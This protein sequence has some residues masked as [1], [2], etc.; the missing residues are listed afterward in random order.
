MS[1]T[2]A[3]IRIKYG[4]Q[5]ICD[6][7]HYVPNQFSPIFGK[8]YQINGTVPKDTILKIAIFDHDTLSKDDLIG[9]TKIDVEDRLRSKYGAACGLQKEYE[10]KGYN[11]WRHPLQP[12]EIL[13]NLCH[14]NDLVPPEYH[15]DHVKV[16]GIE[17][18]DNSLVT[19]DSNV[20]E[21]LA[22]SALNKFKLIPCIGHPLVPEHVETRSLYRKDRPGIE[23]GK[24]QMWIEIFDPKKT[25]PEPVDITPVPPRLYELRCIIWNTKDVLLEESNVFGQKMSDIYVKGLVFQSTKMSQIIKRFFL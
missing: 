5:T 14:E 17:F 1:H 19:K 13:E 16:A 2:D 12:S 9:K 7:A 24:L 25:I 4:D 22:L 11:E 10:R 8:R 6:R 23:Q 18:T 21:R 20:K 15:L 3:F